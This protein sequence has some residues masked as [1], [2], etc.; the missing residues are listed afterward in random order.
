MHSFLSL[1]LHCP[2][3]RLYPF[4]PPSRRQN[5][6]HPEENVGQP[7]C[8]GRQ[9]QV[10][11]PLHPLPPV[12]ELLRRPPALIVRFTS[13]ITPPTR[14]PP[15]PSSSSRAAL[16]QGRQFLLVLH[17]SSNLCFMGFT[18]R[19]SVCVCVLLPRQC[20]AEEGLVDRQGYKHN[21]SISVWPL[22]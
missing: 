1:P 4:L 22:V 7:E 16:V 2:P 19:V 20:G 10:V 13:P 3:N 9:W 18:G 21:V 6:S 8:D 5:R 11:A 12:G 15:T 14:A 17:R